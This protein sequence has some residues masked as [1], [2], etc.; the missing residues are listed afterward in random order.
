ME[1]QIIHSCITAIEM[2]MSKIW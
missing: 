2:L 1:T